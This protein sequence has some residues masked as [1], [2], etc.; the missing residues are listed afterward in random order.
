LPYVL[1][2]IAEDVEA[3]TG[4]QIDTRWILP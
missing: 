1:R 4:L 2:R 3:R